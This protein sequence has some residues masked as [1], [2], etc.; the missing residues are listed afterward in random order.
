MDILLV[1]NTHLPPESSCRPRQI[2][3]FTSAEAVADSDDEG[4]GV[5]AGSA[6][7]VTANNSEG[8]RQDSPSSSSSSDDDSEE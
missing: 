4:D 7:A 6:A 3:Q 2:K 5:D 1:K 8:A